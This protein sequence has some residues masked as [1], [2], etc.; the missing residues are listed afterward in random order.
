MQNIINKIKEIAFAFDKNQFPGRTL[1][2]SFIVY[3]KRIVTIGQNTKKTHPI[4]L[5]NRKISKEGIDISKLCGTCGEWAA[6]RSLK[7]LTNIPAKKCS[8]INIRINKLNE[9]RMSR[10]CHSCI[11]L[12]TF[13]NLD[14]IYYSNNQ[15]QF[16]KL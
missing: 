10:P 1:H 11:S 12:L 2:L 3:K 9:I 14:K 16:Q 4:N 8:L 7:N 5:K 6:L 13:F 15:G